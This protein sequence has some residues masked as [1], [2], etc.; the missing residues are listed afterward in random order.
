MTNTKN[1]ISGQLADGESLGASGLFEPLKVGLLVLRNRFVMPAMQRMRAT[2]GMPSADFV[3]WYGARAAGGASLVISEGAAIDHPSATKSLRILGLHDSTAAGWQACAEAVHRAGSYFLIQLFHEGAVR[4]PGQGPY[5]EAPS[6][7]PSGFLAAG[8]SSGRAAS[9][10]EL[11]EIKEAYVRGARMAERVGADGVESHSAHGYLL[12]QFLWRTTNAR[13][14]QYGAASIENRIRFARE[15]VEA[16]RQVVRRDFVVSFR[17]SQFAEADF[18]A[19]PIESPE[20]LSVLLAGM[21]KAGADIFNLSTRRFWLPEWPAREASIGLAGWARSLTDATVIAVG[22][23]GL[24]QDLYGSIFADVPNSPPDLLGLTELLRRFR[25]GHF[26]LV[27]IGR[28]L[29]ADPDWINKV[30]SNQIET[31]SPWSRALLS[32]VLQPD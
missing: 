21:R 26:D 12:H 20:E 30:A 8:K 9:L 27:A 3:S 7:S 22:S 6:L 14:D 23:V 4:E 28:G 11:E 29:F 31:I 19:K 17:V 32:H 25:A 16:I 24:R 2:G 13:E 1:L 10:S 15:I 5:P 18:E